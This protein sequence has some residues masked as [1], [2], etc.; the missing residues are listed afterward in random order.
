MSQYLP[1]PS[2]TLLSAAHEAKREVTLECWAEFGEGLPRVSGQHRQ[3][4][5]LLREESAIA[6]SFLFFAKIVVVISLSCSM[7][8]K[9]LEV[10]SI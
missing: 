3:L 5:H 10:S 9:W 2:C 1:E 4:P 7:R 8:N 6:S